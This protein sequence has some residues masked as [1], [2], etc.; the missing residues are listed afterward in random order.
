M[1]TAWEA[2]S[3]GGA[4]REVRDQQH[5]VL[6]DF[7]PRAGLKE[8]SLSPMDLAAQSS[9]ALDSAM[10]SIRQISERI[11]SATRDL[12][13]CPDEIQVEFGLKLDA[14]MGAL[15]TRAGVESHLTVTLRWGSDE[16]SGP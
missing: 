5:A 4:S 11:T 2:D 8:V 12:V 13:R 10:A 3:A 14:T 7:A 15:I 1:S 16:S 9:A 6:V